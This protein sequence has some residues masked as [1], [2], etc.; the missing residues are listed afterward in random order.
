VLRRDIKVRQ[1]RRLE[2]SCLEQAKLD[3]V[4]SHWVRR[5]LVDRT[6]VYLDPAFE[7]IEVV[8]RADAARPAAGVSLHS[9]YLVGERAF[10]RTLVVPRKV[11]KGHWADEW[12]DAVEHVEVHHDHDVPA[13]VPS[14]TRTTV[15]VTA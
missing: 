1:G 11:A 10:V 4:P 12:S 5:E 7:L 14:M 15:A 8:E 6:A 2:M 9:E 3:E 13:T